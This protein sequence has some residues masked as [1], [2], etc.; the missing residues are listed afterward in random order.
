[1][2]H[3]NARLVGVDRERRWHSGGN[4]LDARWVEV[5][6]KWQSGTGG[7]TAVVKRCSEVARR[8]QSGVRRWHGQER[9]GG[10]KAVLEVAPRWARR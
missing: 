10:S 2:R 5:A 8:W 1:M 6:R 4:E 7:G 3:V 9:H